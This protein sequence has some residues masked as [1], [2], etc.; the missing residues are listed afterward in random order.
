MT[1]NICG[2]A[3]PPKAQECPHCGAPL[4]PV[5]KKRFTALDLVEGLIF[6]VTGAFLFF[7]GLRGFVPTVGPALQFFSSTP[8]P[9]GYENAVWTAYARFPNLPVVLQPLGH[10][11]W[12]LAGL[13][14]VF[15]G[16]LA[17]TAGKGDNQGAG[18]V[19]LMLFGF[20][21]NAASIAIMYSG[22]LAATGISADAMES[23][24]ISW[25]WLVAQVAAILVTLVLVLLKKR[26]KK[27]QRFQNESEKARAKAARLRAAAVAQQAPQPPAQ[28]PPPQV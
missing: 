1:C 3:V 24:G 15:A 10:L 5:K 13:M 26:A 9:T 14:L 8:T 22:A 27:K 25:P 19:V 4:G 18:A 12:L 23:L 21:A 17:L 20:G 28:N 11:F 7:V 6:L 2:R 16:I